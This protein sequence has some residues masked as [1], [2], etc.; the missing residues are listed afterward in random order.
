MKRIVAKMLG[1]TPEQVTN[2]ACVS[3]IHVNEPVYRVSFK[4]HDQALTT[5]DFKLMDI[6]DALGTM[7]PE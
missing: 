5:T 7:L 6:L 1:I 3:V 2:V 4:G